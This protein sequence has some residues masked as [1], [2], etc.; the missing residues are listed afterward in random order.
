MTAAA[1]LARARAAGLTLTAEAGRLRWRGPPP[2]PDLLA[3]L[4]QHK[5][6]LL[7]MLVANDHPPIL[8][9]ASPEQSAEE[10]ADHAAIAEVDGGK[11]PARWRLV[12]YQ[13][14]AAILRGLQNAALQRP[15]SWPDPAAVLSTGAWCSCCRGSQWWREA[16]HPRGWR[17]STCHPPL[18]G[19]TVVEVQHD[20]Y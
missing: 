19:I 20:P 4:R 9:P 5:G 13:R 12:D 3:E 17:C 10:A 16:E 2:Q 15:P 7:V 14:H 8:P 6:E 11:D 18:H 1:A